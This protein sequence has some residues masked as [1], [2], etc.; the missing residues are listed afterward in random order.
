MDEIHGPIIAGAAYFATVFAAG[1][2]FGIIRE[3]LIKPWIGEF[4]AV[5]LETPFIL[6][7][8]WIASSHL[9][10]SYRIGSSVTAAAI[11]SGFAFTL[12]MIVEIG[13]SLTIEQLKLRAYIQ[14]FRQPAECLGLFVQILFGIC[15]IA[16]YFLLRG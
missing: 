8:S 12:L 10:D 13:S 5:A 7:I 9:M 11:M 16:Q 6:T 14:R 15:P 3:T 2:I 4:R 1:F